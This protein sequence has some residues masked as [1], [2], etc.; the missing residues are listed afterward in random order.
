MPKGVYVRKPRLLT[1][2]E[3]RFWSKVNRTKT[4]WLWTGAVQ[5]KGYGT[6]GRGRN[7]DGTMLA[8][9]FSYEQAYGPIPKDLELDHLCRVRHCV[10]PSHL[11]AVTH[12]ENSLRGESPTCVTHRT[13]V[14]RNGHPQTPENQA[15]TSTACRLCV[16][17]HNRLRYRAKRVA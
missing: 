1:P 16:N 7:Q 15:S 12:R 2:P 4:C 8:H 10:N 13:G 5:S 3:L 11:E 17:A 14:C 6:F 9:R